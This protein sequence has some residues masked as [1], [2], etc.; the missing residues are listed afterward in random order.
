MESTLHTFGHAI[1][2]LCGCLAMVPHQEE[3]KLQIIERQWIYTFAQL[4]FIS[5]LIYAKID[6][7]LYPFFFLSYKFIFHLKIQGVTSWL[8]ANY[9]LSSMKS[10]INIFLNWN[11]FSAYW[12][13]LLFLFFLR[14]EKLEILYKSTL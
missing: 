3:V 1:S 13:N 8:V 7:K 10:Q 6:K 11:L 9:Q 12:I 14:N 4:F 2:S 5:S